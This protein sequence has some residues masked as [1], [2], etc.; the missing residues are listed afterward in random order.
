MTDA[1]GNFLAPNVVRFR[2]SWIFENTQNRNRG[3]I[4]ADRVLRFR[5][6]I[7][8]GFSNP[9]LLRLVGVDVR[10]TILEAS[11]IPQW[12]IAVVE[13]GG[14]DEFLEDIIRRYG[15]SFN[16]RIELNL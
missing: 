15:H 9:E 2:C 13:N 16:Q 11:A 6:E 8:A 3:T 14:D 7:D 5:N 1:V 12:R 10:L 4:G